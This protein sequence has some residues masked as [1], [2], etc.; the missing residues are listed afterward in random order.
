MYNDHQFHYGYWLYAAALIN[1]LDPTWTGLPQLVRESH[2]QY[3]HGDRGEAFSTL[4]ET[5]G[6][7]VESTPK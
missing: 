1:H 5:G 3:A 6:H 4:G 7:E 2:G